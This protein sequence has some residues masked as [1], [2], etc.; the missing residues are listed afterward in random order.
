MHDKELNDLYSS[1]NI[2]QV[3]KSRRMRWATHVAHTG[4]E[5]GV[6]RVLVGKPE[7]KRPLGRPR[8]RW[9]YNI[10]IDLQEVGCGY[11]DWIGLAQDRV[12]WW[13]F[14]SAVMNLRVP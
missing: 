13:T 3:I 8:R 11:V 1:L 4:E 7:G 5:R 10:R 14:V 9:V 12:R 6:Y 2:V